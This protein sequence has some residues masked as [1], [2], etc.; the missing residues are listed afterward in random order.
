MNVPKTLKVLAKELGFEREIKDLGD[1]V[2]LRGKFETSVRNAEDTFRLPRCERPS[3]F[4]SRIAQI[5]QLFVICFNDKS[6]VS[7]E[8]LVDMAENIVNAHISGDEPINSEGSD[9]L[10]M[11][12][13]GFE[14]TAKELIKD[15]QDLQLLEESLMDIEDSNLHLLLTEQSVENLRC[16]VLDNI[17]HKLSSMNS[18]DDLLDFAQS[19]W[20]HRRDV[21]KLLEKEV[22]SRIPL[23]EKRAGVGE[24]SRIISRIEIFDED[25]ACQLRKHLFG[26]ISEIDNYL[27]LVLCH[28][29]LDPGEVRDKIEERLAELNA[30]APSIR[31]DEFY[32]RLSITPLG[33]KAREILEE[34]LE[35]V[36]A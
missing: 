31:D 34:E 17:K 36:P 24:I 29:H 28:N 33:C 7:F 2:R 30:N 21:Q 9:N 18:L 23:I 35:E 13:V 12:K 15:C 3:S 20:D 16:L 27:D 5:R 11:I 19:N 14:I 4:D 1:V 22:S 8:S 32:Y 25:I 6:E 26:F 10:D